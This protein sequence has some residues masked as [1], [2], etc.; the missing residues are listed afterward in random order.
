MDYMDDEEIYA[1]FKR[2]SESESEE[3]EKKHN[4]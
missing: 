4:L 3:S 2:M 1:N